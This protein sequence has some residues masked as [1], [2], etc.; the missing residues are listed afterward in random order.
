M[1]KINWY[2][3]FLIIFIAS[4]SMFLFLNKSLSH[5]INSSS[6]KNYMNYLIGSFNKLSDYN[7]VNYKKIIKENKKLKQKLLENNVAKSINNDLKNEIENLK[8]IT[9]LKQTYTGYKMI[10]AKA[11]T[12]N[13]M[14]W[15]NTITIDKGSNDGITK[16]YAVVGKDGLIGIVKD[17]TKDTSTVKLVTNSDIGNKISGMIKTKD[18]TNIGLIEGYEYPYLKVSLTTNEQKVQVGDSFHTSG[19][20][21]IPK[22]IY[23]GQVEKIEKDSFDLNYILY[24]KPKQDMN[25]IDY[26]IVLGN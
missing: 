11:I 6:A 26:V 22:N 9:K 7:L 1:K 20:S 16:D 4:F 19:L 24:V 15:F 14:Y 10:Y 2:Y 21:N 5:Y 17:T 25:D 13:K 23:I 12:R 3:K 8:K 18:S